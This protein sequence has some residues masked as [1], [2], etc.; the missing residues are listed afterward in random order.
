VDVEE[1]VTVVG[2]E[3]VVALSLLEDEEEV[4]HLWV[5][6]GAVVEMMPVQV[7]LISVSVTREC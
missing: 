4:D 7:H 3:V 5:W 1:E 2:E 6:R